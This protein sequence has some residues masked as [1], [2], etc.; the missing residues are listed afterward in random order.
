MAESDRERA[1]GAAMSGPLPEVATKLIGYDGAG[2]LC[3]EGLSADEL[4]ELYGTP[5]YAVSEQVLR[6][7]Y[8]RLYQAFASR[9]PDVRIAYAVKANNGAAVC[10]VLGNEGAGAECFGLGELTVC[11]RAGIPPERIWLNG[12]DKKEPELLWAIQ[13]GATINVDNP[14]EL[15]RISILA[16]ATALSAHVNLRVK[17]PLRELSDV[18][19]TDYRYDPPVVRLSQWAEGHKFGMTEEQALQC[20]AA[21]Q[22]DPNIDLVGLHHHLKGQTPEADYFRVAAQEA[23]VFLGR[24]RD[25]TGWAPREVDLGGGLAFGQEN[26]Y[27]PAARDR[28]VPSFDDYA[29][30]ITTGFTHAC[31]EAGIPLPRIVLEPGRAL[32]ADAAI[33]L[34]TVGTVKRHP[35]HRP[36]IHVD[37]SINQ[38]I[39]TYTGNWYYEIVPTRRVT[40]PAAITADVVGGLCDAAD[41]LGRERELPDVARGDVLA[42]LDVGAYAESAASTFN[43]EPRALT[44]LVRGTESEVVTRRESVADVLARQSV[45]QW[46]TTGSPGGD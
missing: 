25:E 41:V 27:G 15:E 23:A 14:E 42:L 43:T 40:S 6:R 3:V 2:R 24:L 34:T 29:E 4:V 16:R 8:R 31:H 18:T 22:Q 46:L 21:A 30:A 45:P 11:E 36:W 28:R 44:A 7:N 19:L 26:G 12:S 13:R 9:Y 39:R 35:G 10:A 33:L 1:Q 17:L 32:V 20:C 5:T 37:A 38:A